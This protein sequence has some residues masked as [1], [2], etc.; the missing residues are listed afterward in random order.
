MNYGQLVGEVERYVPREKVLSV[1][2]VDGEL[3]RPEE[4]VQPIIAHAGGGK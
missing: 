2:R 4:I 3:F 1:I